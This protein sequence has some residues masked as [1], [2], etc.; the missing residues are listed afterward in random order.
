MPANQTSSAAFYLLLGDGRALGQ[1]K[2]PDFRTATVLEFQIPSG[3]VRL[4]A[5]SLRL[6]KGLLPFRNVSLVML[7]YRLNEI[8]RYSWRQATVTQVEFP[9]VNINA[10]QALVFSVKL[11]VIVNAQSTPASKKPSPPIY[12]G[13]SP[14]TLLASNIFRFRIDGLEA[15]SDSVSQVGKFTIGQS[16]TGDLFI[17]VAHERLAEPFRSW[18]Q[19]GNAPKGG[20]LNYLSFSLD[21]VFKVNFTGLRIRRIEPAITT[22]ASSPAKIYLACSGAALAPA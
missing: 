16:A 14:D 6:R 9:A 18:L 5:D 22:L 12:L 19:Y 2:Q 7:D 4:F 13:G 15:A 11:S 20:Y 8:F 17:A 10:N 1:I 3:M 21:S